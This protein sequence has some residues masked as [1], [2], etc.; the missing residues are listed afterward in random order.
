MKDPV[1]K[2]TRRNGFT[3]MEVLCTAT[4][5]AFIIGVILMSFDLINSSWQVDSN[6]VNLQ[7]QVRLAI[8][9]MSREIRQSRLADININPDGESIAFAVGGSA[10]TYSLDNNRYIIRQDADGNTMAIGN[11]ISL[12]NFVLAGNTVKITVTGATNTTRNNVSFNLA[13]EVC[14]RN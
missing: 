14:L 12:L 7:Q 3:L 2:I 1:T 10:V 4:L 11:S 6:S 9:R 5:L 13:E 8:E